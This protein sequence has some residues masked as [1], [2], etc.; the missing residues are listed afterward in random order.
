[1]KG[2][3]EKV[4]ECLEVIVPFMTPIPL[5][6]KCKENKC[7]CE[8]IK[9]PKGQRALDGCRKRKPKKIAFTPP[10]VMGKAAPFLAFSSPAFLSD[11]VGL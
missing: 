1:M 3:E 8:Q 5:S 11:P 7:A 9:L 4:R 2:A 10:N 6:F